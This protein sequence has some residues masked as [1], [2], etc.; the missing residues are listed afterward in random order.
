METS[1]PKAWLGVALR[2]GVFAFL[3]IAG[4]M[5]FAQVMMPVAGYLTTSVLSTF[6]A[7]AVANAIAL[8]IYERA[9]LADIGLG[10]S[11]ASR[12]NLLLGLAGG[13]GAALLVTLAPLAARL[14][15]FRPDPD[16]PADWGSF[17]FLAFALLFGAVGEEM[18]FRGY[19]FQILI[20]KAGPFTTILPVSVL[21]GFAHAGNQSASWMG[22]LNTML[23]GVLLG[24]AFVRSGDLWLPIGLHYGWNA[25]L[26]LGG[27]NLSGFK[28]GVTGYKMHW[29][30]GALWSGGDY[31]PEGSLLT[32][33]VVVALF[34]YLMRAP[35]RKQTAYL[36]RHAE[37]D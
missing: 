22:L 28:M 18:L 32:T 7:A 2:V 30:A 10:W 37:E 11:A 31:G 34:G 19:G 33:T 14:A 21:F 25:V 24:V 36:L 8:R 23:W 17:A 13:A 29:F 12:R 9:R 5:V 3:E 26:P 6:A 15:E 35:V 16:N 20:A 27:A 1:R 4:L